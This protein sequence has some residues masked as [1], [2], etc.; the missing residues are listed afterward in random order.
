MQTA[1][2]EVREILRQIPD[3]ISLDEIQYQIYVWQKVR[4]GLEAEKVGDVVPQSELK[5]RISRWVER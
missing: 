4:E 3:H 1:K 2:D 5:A